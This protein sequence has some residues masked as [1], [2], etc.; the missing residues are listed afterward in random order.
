[1]DCVIVLIV[2]DKAIYECH[3]SSSTN[4]CRGL[5]HTSIVRKHLSKPLH[6]LTLPRETGSWIGEE[7]QD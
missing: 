3:A 7:V 6:R 4:I 5:F 2:P 1:M